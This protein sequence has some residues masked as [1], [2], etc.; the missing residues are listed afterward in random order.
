MTM[1]LKK[2]NEELTK[3]SFPCLDAQAIR[4]LMHDHIDM[5]MKNI[6]RISIKGCQ[7]TKESNVSKDYNVQRRD[8]E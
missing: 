2:T 5:R 4:E 7:V 6:A 8:R 1:A 3:W